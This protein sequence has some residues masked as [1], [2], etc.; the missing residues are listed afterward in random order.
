MD[1][2]E[3]D[4]YY[5]LD[6]KCEYNENESK[7]TLS[8]LKGN[9]SV[10]WKNIRYLVYDKGEKIKEDTVKFNNEGLTISI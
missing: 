9:F 1:Y 10:S 2:M 8:K 3:K 6:I 5:I 7:L 4:I